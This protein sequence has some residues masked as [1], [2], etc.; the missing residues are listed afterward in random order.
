[1]RA[2][3]SGDQRDLAAMLRTLL[4]AQCPT[5]VVRAHR[6][7]GELPD[8]LWKSLAAAGVF[9]LAVPDDGGGS[10]GTLSDAGMFAIEAGRSLCPTAVHATVLAALA[11]SR[12]GGDGARA[13]LLPALCHGERRATTALWSVRDAS[14]VSPVLT[15]R[16][17]SGG[18]RLAGTLGFVA[19]ADGADLLIVSATA[20]AGTIV[21]AVESNAPGV[22]LEPLVLMGG[23]RASRVHLRDVA[24]AH[25]VAEGVTDDGLRRNANTA[26]ALLSLD[27]VGV[28]EAVIE[29]TVEYTGTREQFGRPIGAFQAAQHLVADM[30]IAVSAARLAAHAALFHLGRGHVAIRETAVARMHA[31]TAAKHA[32]MDAHQLHG[33]MGYV[34]ETDLHLW[35]ERARVLAT[36]GGGADIA[37]AWLEAD[38][39]LTTGGEGKR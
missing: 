9:G 17:D 8:A 27:L 4:A 30:H 1:M 3:P 5:S 25:V 34:T 6:D 28:A 33:G 11:V 39:N 32:T 24:V 22:E 37:A 2:L 15:A 36:L 29:R 20:P 31:A 13:S 35:T 19:D 12:F 38:M 10:G 26:V 16:P 18:W 21:V 23:H 7:S 14:V